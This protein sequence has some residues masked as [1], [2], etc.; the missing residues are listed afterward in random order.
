MKQ[1]A[2]FPN[3]TPNWADISKCVKKKK[4]KEQ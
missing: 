1:A 2:V 4:K 3:S